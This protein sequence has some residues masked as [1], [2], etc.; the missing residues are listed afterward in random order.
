MQDKYATYAPG[1]ESP[2]RDGFAITPSDSD[3]LPEVTRAL[4]VGAEGT[5]AVALAS[6]ASVTLEGVSA[7]TLLPLRVSRVL[8]TGTTASAIIGLV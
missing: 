5:V 4:Y 3:D 1:L 2:A 7:G 8:A 6:G